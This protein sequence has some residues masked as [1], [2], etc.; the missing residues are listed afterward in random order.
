M[1][2]VPLDPFK[3]TEMQEAERKQFN[4]TMNRLKKKIHSVENIM[5]S[6]PFAD[7]H[8]DFKLVWNQKLS[9]ILADDCGI[10][11]LTATRNPKPVYGRQD[12]IEVVPRGT[13]NLFISHGVYV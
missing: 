3:L 12:T 13:V 7:S 8:E 6:Q 1:A 11:A 4:G 5:Y 2:T 10:S 9:K